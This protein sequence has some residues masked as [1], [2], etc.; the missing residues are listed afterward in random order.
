MCLFSRRSFCDPSTEYF[1]TAPKNVNPLSPTHSTLRL[2]TC[3]TTHYDCWRVLCVAFEPYW[4]RRTC[5]SVVEGQETLL[6]CDL[7]LH[8]SFL[9]SITISC[10]IFSL[11]RL[12]VLSL[13]NI[14]LALLVKSRVSPLSRYVPFSQSNLGLILASSPTDLASFANFQTLATLEALCSRR[15]SNGPR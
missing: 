7:S 4:H 11:I 13:P 6:S 3:H 15:E 8:T 2:C 9:L 10:A 5:R 14:L 12:L 1:D